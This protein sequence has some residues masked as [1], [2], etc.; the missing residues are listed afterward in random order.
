MIMDRD[1]IVIVLLIAILLLV[2]LFGAG[3]L[4]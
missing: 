1:S 3:V 2:V 4:G